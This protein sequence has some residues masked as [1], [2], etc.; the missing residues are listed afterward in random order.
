MRGVDVVGAGSNRSAG[1]CRTR[2]PCPTRP[3]AG[4]AVR[5]ARASSG[6]A[7]RARPTSDRE[8]RIEPRFE[9]KDESGMGDAF[10]MIQRVR[11][12][13]RA[14][15]RL[16]ARRTCTCWRCPSAPA[17]SARWGSAS[18][19]QSCSW[20]RRRAGSTGRGSTRSVC[21]YGSA[22]ND[23]LAMVGSIDCPVMYHYG[24]ADDFIPAE[25]VDADQ[26][27]VALRVPASSS[28]GNQAPAGPRLQQLGRAV[29]VPRAR[30]RVGMGPLDRVPR[31]GPA[32]TRVGGVCKSS[33]HGRPGERLVPAAG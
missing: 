33:A 31:R 19:A 20:P 1:S 17:G 10:G 24:E 9:R 6:T 30:G 5:C 8:P 26:R 32:L 13:P 21:Y 12:R 4:T 11:V 22:I 3:C 16:Y 28:T 27:A 7:R 14:G 23:M 25:N 29:D 15:R 2:R 18:A